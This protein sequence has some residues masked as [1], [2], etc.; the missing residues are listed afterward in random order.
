MC[1]LSVVDIF[2]LWLE[3]RLKNFE[4]LNCDLFGMFLIE[5]GNIQLK[6][7]LT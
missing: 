5:M 6:K 4:S 2:H 1:G 3:Y 7:A